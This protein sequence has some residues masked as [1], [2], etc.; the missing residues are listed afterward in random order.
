MLKDKYFIRQ[1]QT[2]LACVCASRG[3]LRK[4]QAAIAAAAFRRACYTF[5]ARGKTLLQ[6]L[7]AG[8]ALPLRPSH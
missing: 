8:A 5:S 2:F 1:A 3:T 4:E 6:Y 7:L